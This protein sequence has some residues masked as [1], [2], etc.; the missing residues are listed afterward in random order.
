MVD[1]LKQ[2]ESRVIIAAILAIMVIEIFA[3]LKGFNG[4]LLTMVVG[5]LAALGGWV[6]PQLKLQK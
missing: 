4:V 3:L 1:K 5:V 6:A 2:P